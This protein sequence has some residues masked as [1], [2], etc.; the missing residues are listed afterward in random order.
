MKLQVASLGLA[1]IGASAQWQPT[2][3]VETRSLEDIYAAAQEEAATNGSNP[4]Q[5]A[6][7]GDGGRQGQGVRDMWAARFPDIPLNLT[8]DLSKFHDGRQDIAFYEGRHKNDIAVLQTLQDF[9][10][11]KAQNR[12]MYYK[13]REFDDIFNGE[14]DPDGAWLGL[15]NY[16][17]GRL[18]YDNTKLNAS[19]VPTTF[20]AFQ[21]PAWKSKLILTYP[22]DDDAVAYLFALIV[23]KYGHSWLEN[24]ARN[25]V[26]WVKGTG[27]PA[28]EIER[29]HNSTDAHCY[30]TFTT[31]DAGSE[32]WWGNDEPNDQF[33]TWAQTGAIFAN[34]PRPE[35]SK[36]F[37]SWITSPEFQQSQSSTQYGLHT[38]E[39]NPLL[40]N[41]TQLSG[42]RQFEETRATV[43]WWKN[44]FEDVLGTPQGPSPLE[45]YPNPP[46]QA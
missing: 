39:T 23:S 28:W 12:L 26:R 4:L 24:L 27:T 3:P 36:L 22:N 45:V 1:A 20:E 15:F 17:F 43:E 14:K 44:Q 6:W 16:N 31:G 38:V 46:Y 13:P 35:A 5:V 30:L 37:I 19:A 42:F 34:T 25:D 33:V 32:T 18:V 29:L 2:V 7:G 40:S 41:R 11:W 8:V 9:P 21:D 10:R